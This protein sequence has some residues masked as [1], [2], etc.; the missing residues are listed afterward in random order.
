[1]NA[2]DMTRC[3]RRRILIMDNMGKEMGISRIAFGPE[4]VRLFWIVL[5]VAV[6]FT[7]IGIILGN[8]FED[9]QAAA[10]L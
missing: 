8:P 4:S 1:M 2:A 3:R 5:I 9:Y 7:V 6:V 10:T